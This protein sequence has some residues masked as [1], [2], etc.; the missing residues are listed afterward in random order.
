MHAVPYLGR[1]SVTKQ[2]ESTAYTLAFNLTS[3]FCVRSCIALL[4]C[5]SILHS[6]LYCL[7]SFQYRLPAFSLVLSCVQSSIA[8]LHSVLYHPP[9]FSLVSSAFIQSCITL[10]RS[11]LYCPSVFSLNH[12]S[13]LV[14]YRSSAFGLV[15][16]FVQ[17]CIA[18]LHSMLYRF[19]AFNLVSFFCIQHCIVLLHSVL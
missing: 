14:L 2:H 19:S 4:P 6:V 12:P 5:I 9:S 16:P 10:L 3:S 15:S 18:L 8:F 11:I 17:T 1:V 7:R 13:S